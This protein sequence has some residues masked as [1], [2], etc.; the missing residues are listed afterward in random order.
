MKKKNAI[1]NKSLYYKCHIISETLSCLQ[2][3][4]GLQIC[5]DDP[6]GAPEVCGGGQEA[7]ERG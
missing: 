4:R 5:R 1:D 3:G 6:G 7:R 2:G